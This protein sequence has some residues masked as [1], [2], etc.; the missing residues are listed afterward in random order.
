MLD[1]LN[2]VGLKDI[3]GFD[4]LNG[5]SFLCHYTNITLEKDQESTRYLL[6]LSKRK[7]IVALPE[8]DTLFISNDKVDVIGTKPYYVFD[9]GVKRKIKVNN[10]GDNKWIE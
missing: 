5:I 1:D 3:K 6:E 4:V 2:E 8:E 10:G 9:R 7:K